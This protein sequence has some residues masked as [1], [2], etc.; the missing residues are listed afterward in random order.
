MRIAL[1]AMGTDSAPF[2]EI[3]GAVT[4]LRRFERDC[5]ILLVGDEEADRGGVVPTFRLPRGSH[6]R[7]S[8]SGPD[9]SW[10]SP[11]GGGA[12]KAELLHR[13]G[14]E[15][16]EG[17][18][19]RRFCQR[20]VHRGRHGCLPSFSSTVCRVWTGRP[21]ER[22]FPLPTSRRFLLDAGANVDCKPQHLLQ[23]AHLGQSMPRTSWEWKTPGSGF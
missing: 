14:G 23:F 5:E 4:A 11:G 2:N 20:R 15:A 19:G 16:S 9:R 8:C 21:S 18:E 17:G 7:G 1:D 3:E 6:L 10:G 22:C 12:E 13:G